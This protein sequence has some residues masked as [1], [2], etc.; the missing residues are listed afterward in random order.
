MTNYMGIGNE[1][2]AIYRMEPGDFVPTVY[3]YT[4]TH[5]LTSQSWSH[6]YNDPSLFKVVF[7]A[8]FDQRE[9]QI[10][11]AIPCTEYINGPFWSGFT[12]EERDDA[13]GVLIEP[14][15]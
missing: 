4:K 7:K 14:R 12:Q 9:M 8:Y 2:D 13:I 3:L 11:E 1:T 10:I 15:H 6:S 5:N